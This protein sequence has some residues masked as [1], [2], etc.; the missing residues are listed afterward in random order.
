[1][2]RIILICFFYSLLSFYGY[3]ASPNTADIKI[4]AMSIFLY[5][6]ML[7]ESKQYDQAVSYLKQSSE[8]LPGEDFIRFKLA[9]TYIHLRENEAAFQ[10]LAPLSKGDTGYAGEADIL[11][12]SICLTEKKEEDALFY[13]KHALN[14]DQKN[15]NTYY[16]LSQLYEEMGLTQEAISTNEKAVELF[17]YE[18]AFHSKLAQLYLIDKQYSKAFPHFKTALIDQDANVKLLMGAALCCLKLSFLE[19]AVQYLERALKIDP[20]NPS[21]YSELI[22]L[23]IRQK[24]YEDAFHICE[25]WISVNPSDITGYLNYGWLALQ[26][27]EYEKGVLF[28]Q[29]NEEFF[30]NDGNYAYCLARLFIGRQNDQI[31]EEYFKKALSLVQEKK[32]EVYYHYALMLRSQGRLDEAVKM[33]EAGLQEN[34]GHALSCNFLGYLLLTMNRPANEALIYI[35]KAV[36]M[37]PENPAFLDSM[38]WALYKKGNFKEAELYLEQASRFSDSK[39]IQ[40]HLSAVKQAAVKQDESKTRPNSK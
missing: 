31:A 32:Y 34:P 28:L 24:E 39:E 5:G 18:T 19:D 8:L 15:K 26:I 21:I 13:L 36:S 16:V 33:L 1:M 4:R 30:S 23:K 20:L 38:G 27:E 40:E 25:Q 7:Y 10:V 14:I 6:S 2:I 12:A 35:E 9:Q 11:L 17:P 37:E 3:A 29:K 22:S